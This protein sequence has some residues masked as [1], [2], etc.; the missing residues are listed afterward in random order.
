MSHTRV[1]DP[2]GSGVVLAAG[3]RADIFELPQE[4]CTRALL[5]AAFKMEVGE[6]ASV[7]T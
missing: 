4:A 1:V 7:A 3:E 6:V 2:L 5:A